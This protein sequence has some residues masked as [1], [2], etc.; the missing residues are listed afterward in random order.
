MRF[1]FSLKLFLNGSMS[2]K[3]IFLLL[4][5][6]SFTVNLALPVSSHAQNVVEVKAG[7]GKY[8]FSASGI[9]SPYASVVMTT[10]DTF[11]ASTIADENGAFELP[12]ALVNEGFTDYCIEA[13]DVKRVGTSYTCFTTEPAIEDFSEDGLFLAPTVGLSGR[14]ITPDSGIVASGYSMP[15]SDVS[16]NLREDLILKS[17]ADEAGFYKLAIENVPTGRYEIYSMSNYQSQISEKPTRTFAIESISRLSELPSWVW[18]LIL[19][20]IVI[21]ILILFFILWKRRKKKKKKPEAKK[22]SSPGSFSWHA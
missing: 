17:E 8:Y 2:A 14:K 11:M 18:F 1:A 10:Q 4:I 16:I 6:A 21:A 13:V 9:V 15:G 3:L 22:T 20:L 19:V 7:V 12:E 5:S